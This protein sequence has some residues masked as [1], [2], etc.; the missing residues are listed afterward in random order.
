MGF[1]INPTIDSIFRVTIT[2]GKLIMEICREN[3]RLY[4]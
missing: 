1:Q 2:V 4:H 3:G